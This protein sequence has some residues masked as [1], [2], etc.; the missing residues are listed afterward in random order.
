MIKV[1]RTLAMLI[2]KISRGILYLVLFNVYNMD[3]MT[4]QSISDFFMYP[5]YME[6]VVIRCHYIVTNDTKRD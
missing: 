6:Y 4:K 1:S 3:V 2:V 5:K